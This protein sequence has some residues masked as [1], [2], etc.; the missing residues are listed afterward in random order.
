[1]I[2]PLKKPLKKDDQEITTLNLDFDSLTGLQ[3]ADAEQEARIAGNKSVTP[4]HT[5]HGQAFVAAKACGMVPDDI[6]K[7]SGPDFMNV[8]GLTFIFLNDGDLPEMKVSKHST[9]S[10]SKS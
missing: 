3:I 4:L 7:L 2:I 1:M 9:D 6:F 8:T 10:E 5:V